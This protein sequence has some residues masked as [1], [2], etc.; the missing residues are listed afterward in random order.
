M[1]NVAI[2]TSYP[3]E[4]AGTTRSIGAHPKDRHYFNNLQA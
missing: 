1:M 2:D 4:A 3:S